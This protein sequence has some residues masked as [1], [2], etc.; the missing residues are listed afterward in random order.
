MSWIGIVFA[1]WRGHLTSIVARQVARGGS[2]NRKIA[3]LASNTT[4]AE[5]VNVVDA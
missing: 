3:R 5:N 1:S 4:G 2:W